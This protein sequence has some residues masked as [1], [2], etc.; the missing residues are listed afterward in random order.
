MSKKRS[1]TRRDFLNGT[2]LALGST[3]L[4]PLALS[5]QHKLLI[6]RDYYPPSLTGMRGSHDGSYEVAHQLGRFGKRDWGKVH[7]TEDPIYDLVVVGAGISGLA[8]A[9]FYQQKFGEGARILLLDNHDDFGGHAKRNEFNVGNQRPIGYGGS[10]SMESPED[11]SGESKALLEDLGVDLERFEEAYHFDFFEDHG[12]RSMTFF[13]QKL[14]GEHRLVPFTLDEYAFYDIPGLIRDRIPVEEALQQM[15]LKPEVKTQLSRLLNAAPDSLKNIS[16][17]DRI[18]YSERTSYFEFLKTQLEI[19]DSLIFEW[20][21]MIPAGGAGAADT[22][23]VEEALYAGMPGINARAFLP[24][25][26]E[27]VKESLV[28]DKDFYFHHFPDGNA[29]IA[30]LL[31]RKLIP[32]VAPGSTMEDIVLAPFDYRQLDHPDSNVRLRLNS[33]VVNVIHQGSLDQAKQVSVTYVHN[34]QVYRV[35]AKNC[36][37]ACYNMI[38]PHIIPELPSQQKQALKQLVKAPLVYTNV[39]LK[40]WKAL[41][42]LGVGAAH[43]P[44]QLH[45]LVAMDY[46]VSLGGYR[47]PLSPEQP[48]VLHMEY[49]PVSSVPGLPLRDQYRE[50]RYKLLAM[51]FSQF[52]TEIKSHLRAMLG[53]GGFDPE[54]DIRA[55]TVNR[56]SHGY[57]YSGDSLHDEEVDEDTMPHIIGRQPF[58]RITIANSDAGA[59]AYMN[60]AIDQAWRAVSEIDI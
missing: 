52:E 28:P 29:S 56:W 1:I 14:F 45:F 8:A 39:L 40:N 27:I 54:Q 35:R 22:M 48:M 7:S 5:E 24:L 34:N 20:L 18:D 10:Q 21:R 17:F 46:P 41:K 4:P 44:G 32:K 30:R 47:A 51:P 16:F 23:T 55:I 6:D 31:V 36:V 26:G 53:P 2:L 12:L 13:D 3:L 43:C 59:N 49:I 37:M 19:E 58:G 25:L 9:R 42:N 15:P 57:A 60:E 11:Y 33:T 50:G 38:I